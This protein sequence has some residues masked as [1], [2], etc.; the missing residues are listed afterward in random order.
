MISLPLVNN[1]STTTELPDALDCLDT[2]V[3]CANQRR[4]VVLLDFDGTITPIVSHPHDAVLTGSMR[5]TLKKLADVC[6]LA[7]IS[8]RDALD[9]CQRVALSGIYCV[10]NHGFEI[11]AGGGERIIY[12]GGLEFLPQLDLAEYDLRAGLSDVMGCEVERKHFAVAVHYRNLSTQHTSEVRI[13][14]DNIKAAHPRLRLTRG[15]KIL[16]LRPDTPWNKGSALNW[17]MQVMKLDP[18][19]VFAVYVGDDDTDEDAFKVLK[20]RGVGIAVAACRKHTA[21][22]YRLSDV[23]DVQTFLTQLRQRLREQNPP[24]VGAT[25]KEKTKDY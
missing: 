8:G 19:R 12:Q 6:P 11:I 1:I 15:K 13:R 18:Q 2:I 23:T 21:A 4:I 3:R 16:E 7:I 14:V 9:V 24:A 22:R 20:N 17:L 5:T 25:A 10:G